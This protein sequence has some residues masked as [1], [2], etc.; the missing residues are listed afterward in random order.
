MTPDP[1]PHEAL[2]RFWCEAG[3]GRW[4][5]RDEAFDAVLR[6]RFG[7]LQRAAVE[8]GFED[9]EG[10]ARGALAL[11]LLVDQLPRNLHRGAAAAFA[12]DARARAVADRA[13]ARGYDHEVG[14]DLAVFFIMPFEH[15]EDAAAQARAVALFEAHV[16]A[17]GDPRRH[18]RYARLHAALIARFGRFP[19]RN[20]ALGRESTPEE[21]AYL[22]GGGF[23]G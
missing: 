19:H 8:G 10:T 5:R 20:A 23:K 13:L 7:D 1:P 16:A 15:A 11:V 17:H 22:A 2:V 3:P 21:L 12:G 4:F 14:P 6:A 18:L 9:W